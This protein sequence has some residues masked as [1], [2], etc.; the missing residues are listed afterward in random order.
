[1]NRKPTL[2]ES[3]IGL[4]V[5]KKESINI[6]ETLKHLME[7]RKEVEKDLN[8]WK[9][10]ARVGGV[11]GFT[12][13]DLEKRIQKIDEFIRYWQREHEDLKKRKIYN[14]QSAEIEREIEQ[15]LEN[16]PFE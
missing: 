12:I 8:F 16:I 10:I 2:F 1:M 3:F 7:R 13:I 4:Q 9:P 15:S 6:E 11:S 5:T 14:K